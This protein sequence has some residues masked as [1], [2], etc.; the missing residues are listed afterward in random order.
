V[1]IRINESTWI[2]SESIMHV[3]IIETGGASKAA[4]YK[5]L[6]VMQDHK[7]YVSTFSDFA[8]AE[9]YV[10]TLEKHSHT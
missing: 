3:K 6:I 10:E 7:E 4:R 9:R 8:S 2:P 5:V 1:H